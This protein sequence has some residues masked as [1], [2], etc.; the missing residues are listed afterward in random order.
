MHIKNIHKISNQKTLVNDDYLKM[1]VNLFK[2]WNV[3]VQQYKFLSWNALNNIIKNTMMLFPVVL[4]KFALFSTEFFSLALGKKSGFLYS[5][6]FQHL[7]F[8]KKQDLFVTQ[9]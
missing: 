2:F 3:K 7:D 8:L 1:L 9:T 4:Q 5:T 6:I